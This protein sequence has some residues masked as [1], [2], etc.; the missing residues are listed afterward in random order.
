MT[1]ANVKPAFSSRRA[2]T[3][4]AISALAALLA[5]SSQSAAQTAKELG[6]WYDDTGQGVVELY[7]CGAKICGRIVWLRD[8]I[9]R[10]GKP[11]YDGYNPD[12]SKRS[13][14]ICGLQILGN[15][16]RQADGTLDEGWV[17]DPKQGIYASA[18][19]T[20]EGKNT[21]TLTGYK[22]LRLLGK[23]FTWTRAPAD[24]KTCEATPV[25]GS[26]VR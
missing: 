1:N 11:L 10:D 25:K 7:S 16:T 9:A 21:L 4:A 23:S 12:P 13:R 20:L 14:A 26:A 18:A 15:L 17:Y 19:I 2:R 24:L 3:S 22:G 5:F 6:R 8:P